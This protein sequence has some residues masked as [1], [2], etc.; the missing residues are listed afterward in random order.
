M[1][2]AEAIKDADQEVPYRFCSDEYV[3]AQPTCYRFDSGA[4]M[5]ETVQNNINVYENYYWFY[6]FKR[7]RSKFG[8]DIGN[9][10]GR[11]YGRHFS[12]LSSQF[13][14]MT[15][16]EFFTD[17]DSCPVGRFEDAYP[18]YAATDCGADMYL[19]SVDTLNFFQRV[20]GRPDVGT[21]GYNATSAS[22]E[23]GFDSTG[24]DKTK[25]K[26]EITLKP[27]T[28]RYQ[29]TYYS[30]ERYG[31]DF[32]YKP[33]V[34]GNWWDKFLAVDALGDPETFFIQN[35]ATESLQ[36]V[37]NFRVIFPS[38]VNNMVGAFITES[39]PNYAPSVSKDGS[40][41]YRSIDYWSE[42]YAAPPT[43][44][45][46]INP[47]EQYT[48][49][50]IAAFDGLMYF[51]DN[52]DQDFTYGLKIFVKGS[53]EGAVLPANTE[54]VEV[55]DPVSNRTFVAIKYA[56][57]QAKLDTRGR[58]VLDKNG[59]PVFEAVPDFV[60]ISFEYLT[61]LKKR[62]S[63]NPQ[64]LHDELYFVDIIRDAVHLYEYRQ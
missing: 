14:Q 41:T 8:L 56:P 2:K 37:F 9:Y 24:G 50:L 5:W 54:Y 58:P 20:L 27:G 57:L 51:T 12:F 30:Y 16:Q 7:G 3:D 43:A 1:V 34:I 29:D 36:Y 19:S 13:K 23:K 4:D 33:V 40:V 21:F 6:N 62:Y 11:V 61:R 55:Q 18:H 48:A 59:K 26:D 49:R 45:K 64:T 46:L 15:N 32:F 63:A 53:G 25:P 10:L 60:P 35:K 42:T 17:R 47:S 39:L 52:Y 28:G 38:P 22:Y 31:Y 44:S